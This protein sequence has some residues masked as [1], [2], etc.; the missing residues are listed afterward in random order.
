MLGDLGARVENGIPDASR[1]VTR[2][3]P[4]DSG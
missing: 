2:S 3:A 4:Y 1:R